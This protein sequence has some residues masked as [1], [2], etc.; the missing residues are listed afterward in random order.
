LKARCNDQHEIKIYNRLADDT[1]HHPGR[2]Y[3]L[4][5]KDHFNIQ[6][7]NGTHLCLVY[8]AMGPSVSHMTWDW[9]SGED[10]MAGQ[11]KRFTLSAARTMLYHLLLGLAFIH[12]KGLAHG[13]FHAGNSLFSLRDMSKAS[14]EDLRQSQE[15][16][17]APVRRLD[18]S[19]DPSAPCFLTLD[20]PLR[21]WV[22]TGNDLQIKISDLGSGKKAVFQAES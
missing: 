18:G 13:D 4:P 7:P 17:S 15:M 16:V 10:L 20:Q 5:L 21:E 3:V 12:S 11:S 22:A 14:I 6:G 1:E 2:P 9:V 8:E 19:N